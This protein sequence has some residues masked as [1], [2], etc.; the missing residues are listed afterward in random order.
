MVFIMRGFPMLD[1]VN[2]GGGEEY[3][4]GEILFG[5]TIHEYFT[6]TRT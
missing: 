2:V 1:Q 3:F 4:H 5:S 6:N